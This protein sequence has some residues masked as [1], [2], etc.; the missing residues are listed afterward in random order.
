LASDLC[1]IWIGRTGEAGQT[2][3]QGSL[4]ERGTSG[5]EIYARTSVTCGIYVLQGILEKG[6]TCASLREI[7]NGET[8]TCH[9]TERSTL[10]TETPET[11]GTEICGKSASTLATFEIENLGNV[12]PGAPKS[13]GGTL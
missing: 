5:A 13:K 9:L 8:E 10:A 4:T 3:F 7:V 6:V 2:S 12:A 11:P 1:A